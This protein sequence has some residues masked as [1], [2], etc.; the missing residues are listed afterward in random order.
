[1][2]PNRAPIKTRQL[3]CGMHKPAPDYVDKTPSCAGC[4]YWG[5]TKC[6]DIHNALIASEQ[7]HNAYTHMMSSNRGIFM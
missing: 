3:L 7:N 4:D 5:G 6:Q 1:M 2:F